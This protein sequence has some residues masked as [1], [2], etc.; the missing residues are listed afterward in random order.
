VTKAALSDETIA[1]LKAKHG[2]LYRI[3]SDL[4]AVVHKHP[5]QAEVDAYLLGSHMHGSEQES[6]N[7]L[8]FGCRVWPDVA[9]VEKMFDEAPGIV[10]KF[11][12]SIM[13]QAG[14]GETD[15]PGLAPR[16]LSTMSA[17][18]KATIEA[19]IGKSLDVLMNEHPRGCL[20][21]VT[22]PG[23]G[24]S[25]FRRPTRSSYA[26]FVDVA[27]KDTAVEAARS[28]C[29]EC[30]V[31]DEKSLPD[32]FARKPAVPFYLAFALTT[33]AGNHLEVRSGKL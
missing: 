4:G 6:C 29:A 23:V 7:N 18:D 17:E 26:A 21:V 14:G 22:L 12:E 27:K 9:T 28:L 32:V 10:D 16:D 13:D 19:R 20:R 1:E 33:L 3:D 30:N 31:T 2:T 25:I 5:G 24:P 8:V 11:A 15:L